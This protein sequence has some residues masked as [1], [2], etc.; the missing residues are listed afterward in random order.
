MHQ[1][2]CV[3]KLQYN[4]GEIKVMGH[5]PLWTLANVVYGLIKSKNCQQSQSFISQEPLVCFLFKT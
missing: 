2:M 4:Y 5:S 3:E 1:G